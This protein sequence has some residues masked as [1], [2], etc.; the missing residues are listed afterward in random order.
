MSQKNVMQENF[1]QENTVQTDVLQENVVQKGTV[2]KNVLQGNMIKKNEAQKK[3]IHGAI[4]DLDG[5]LLDS[6]AVWNDLGVRYLIKRGIQ[7]E[8]GL[9]QILFS[10]SMEQGADYL[11]EHYHLPDTSQEI[12]NGIEQMIRDFYFYEVQPKEGAKELLQF[13]QDQNIKMIAA[14][15]SPREHVTKALQR[16]GLLDYL[17]QIYTTGEVGESKHTPL[18]YQLAAE[19]LGTKPEETLVFEDSLY[20]L[21]TAKNAGFRSIGVYDADGET[22]QEGVRQTGE[23]YLRTLNDFMQYWRSL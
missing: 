5:V 17:Q 1:A 16:T 11:K 3:G 19:S 15:S 2:Q 13:L 9:S 23:L 12:L 8:D 14:T 21:K 18:I 22:D 6:M 7:P 10:M 20:A 4:F